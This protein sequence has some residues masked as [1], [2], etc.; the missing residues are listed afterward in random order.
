M[1]SSYLLA[2]PVLVDGPDSWHVRGE[3]LV[4]R[5]RGIAGP[6]ADQSRLPRRVVTHHHTLYSLDVRPLI[7]CVDIHGEGPGEEEGEKEGEGERE[8]VGRKAQ[9]V[10]KRD[11]L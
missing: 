1:L 6:G 7:V 11:T 2:H 3:Q 8:R 5:E 4:L 10:S 9:S